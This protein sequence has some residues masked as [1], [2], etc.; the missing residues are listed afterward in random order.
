M[1][2]STL[3]SEQ[4]DKQTTNPADAPAQPLSIPRWA[5]IVAALV[6]LLPVLT[7]SSM[8][9]MIGLLG[10]PMHGGMA[11]A[12]PSLFPIVG[13]IPLVLVFAVVYGVYRLC[14]ADTH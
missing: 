1:A 2:E 13:V 11:A 12:G 6:V 5:V 7:I 3:S 4:P 10:P 14:T 9:L 8:M